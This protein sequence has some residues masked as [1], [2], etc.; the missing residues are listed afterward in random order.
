MEKKMKTP[1]YKTNFKTRVCF[2]NI[3]QIPFCRNTCHHEGYQTSEA[4]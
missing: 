1:P 2:L 4:N 3:L